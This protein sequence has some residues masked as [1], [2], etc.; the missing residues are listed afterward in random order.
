MKL[1]QEQ[2]REIYL[3]LP[4]EIKDVAVSSDVNQTIY[5]IC[6]KHKL[7]IDEAGKVYNITM[8]VVMGIIATKNFESEIV[9][10]IKIDPLKSSVIVRDIDEQV[11]APIKETMVRLYKHSNP[12]K[13]Q[14]MQHADEYDEE[15]ETK[16]DRNNL[17]AEI[18]NPQKSEVRKISSE[19]NL[20]MIKNPM[21]VTTSMATNTIQDEEIKEAPVDPL[22][23]VRDRMLKTITDE[24]L[25][26]IVT[27]S[28]QAVNVSKPTFETKVEVKVDTGNHT[29]ES[30]VTQNIIPAIS[31]NIIASGVVEKT[32]PKTEIK[33]IFDI[34]QNIPTVTASA[35]NSSVEKTDIHI[36]AVKKPEIATV[37]KPAV[38]PY[39]EA[40]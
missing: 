28:R 21:S 33:P 16:L 3:K 23:Q 11:L 37:E 4:D 18:E 6:E 22:K 32:E 10:E 26:S 19:N 20:P 9:R 5:N 39:R 34:P 7:H 24:K 13:P 38:D 36:D 35:T 40:I 27:M 8:D 15:D 2:Y 25:T 31:T 29:N 30:G 12:F 1:T 17:L 14:T